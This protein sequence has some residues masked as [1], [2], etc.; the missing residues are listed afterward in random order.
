LVKKHRVFFVLALSAIALVWV[1]SNRFWGDY[2]WSNI[3]VSDGPGYYAYLP[4]IVVYHDLSF[5]F[6]EKVLQGENRENL[7]YDYRVN[8]NGHIINKYFSGTA[9]V[10]LPFYILGHLVTILSDG[11]TDGYSRWYLVFFHVGALFYCLL[12]LF[13]F[14]RILKFYMVSE[15]LSASG[16]GFSSSSDLSKS[17]GR[18]SRSFFLSRV[19]Y[20]SHLLHYS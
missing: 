20:K 18:F 9:F 4:A 17:D 5:G 3:L 11:V 6:F 7:H 2:R 19:V 10:Q 15:G 13:V 12:G 16:C 1:S 14:S 8:T